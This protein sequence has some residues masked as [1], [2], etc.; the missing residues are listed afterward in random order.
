M[1]RMLYVAMTGA[2]QT[3]L[4][5]A[6]NA[7]NLANANT[8]G[9][10]ADLAAMRAA[11]LQ[12]GGLPTRVY[13]MAENPGVDLDAGSLTTTGRD[14]DVAVNG[15]GYIAV[16][17]PD[18]S[19]AY[20]RAGDLRLTSTGLLTT[21]AGHPVLGDGGPITLPP[22]Q[23]IDIGEDGTI[24]LLPIGQAPK[25]LAVIDRIRLVR[26]AGAT[27]VKGNDGLLRQRSGKP[28]PPDARVRLVSGAVEGSNV[29]GVEAMV[30]MLSL[31]R[32]FEMQVKMMRTAE[33]NDA[34]SAELLRLA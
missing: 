28:A 6:V 13:A 1:D 27:L 14:L 18:G 24:S 11:A 4:A 19:E 20:T 23:K 9:F 31:S 5:Q 21:G 3:M 2:H 30:N 32:E 29:N 10:R 22:A 33:R 25:A 12:G 7:N 34:S 17:A 16:Q 15:E 26:P 8:T